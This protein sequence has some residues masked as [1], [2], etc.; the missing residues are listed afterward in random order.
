MK[1]TWGTGIFIFLISFV[2]A[3]LSFVYFAFQQDVNLVNKEYYQKG[4]DFD[5]ERAQKE[6]GKEQ[7][8]NFKVEQIDGEVIISV[9]QEYFSEISETEAY[10]YRPSDRHEDKKIPFE[11]ERLIVQKSELI[12]GRYS[13]N[14]SWKKNDE[15]YLLEKYFYLK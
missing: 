3:I 13:L 10:F 5:L 14:I 12:K 4:V 15:A 7:E 6:R 8:N 9:N 11:S 2:I 1:F